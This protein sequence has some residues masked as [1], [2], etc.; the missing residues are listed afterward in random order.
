MCLAHFVENVNA[1]PVYDA[2]CLEGHS[3]LPHLELQYRSNLF[4]Q[5]CVDPW[6]ERLEEG[7][8]CSYLS[9]MLLEKQTGIF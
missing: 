1:T 4:I 5:K 6:K 8:I 7:T 9:M 2:I 3:H